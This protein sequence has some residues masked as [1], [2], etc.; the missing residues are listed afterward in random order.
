MNIID[1]K[2]I[3]KQIRFELKNT[4]NNMVEKPGLGIILVGNK[5]E[6]HSYV[7]MKKKACE[8]VGIFNLD[9][10]MPENSSQEEIIKCIKD[11][12]NNPKI[13]GI[14]VQLPLPN[15]LNQETILSYVDCRKDV[16]G[17]HTKNMGA[18]ALNQKK[19][20]LTPCTPQGCIELLQRSNIEIEGKHIVMVGCSNIVGLPLSLLLIH[21]GAT[22]TVCHIKTPDIS[23]FTKLADIVIVAC[24]CPGLI[25]SNHLKVGAVVIDVGINYVRCD[26]S[27]NGYKIVGDVNYDDVID[28]VSAITPVP[29]GVGPM[30]IAMLLKN[31]VL[32]ADNQMRQYI[33]KFL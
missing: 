5:R 7:K 27:K 19:F 2:T 21:K 9:C 11:L 10:L 22:V 31:T 23:I 8:E 25:T 20:S 24:G 6:S 15:H 16:D 13:H 30:T 1:G 28:K 32:A 29:G 18:L 12:N 3:A 33:N 17:F 26:K 14:L 4:V